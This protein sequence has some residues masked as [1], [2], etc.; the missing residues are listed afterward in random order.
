MGD[1]YVQHG[2]AE[3]AIISTLRNSTHIQNFY[4]GEPN[5]APDM[6][7]YQTGALWIECSLEG[8]TRMWPTIWR[9]RIDVNVFAKTRS[10]AHD[11][12]QV[13]EAVLFTLRGDRFPTYG[14]SITGVK[15]ET[16]M[17]RA[18]DALTG[19][20]RYVFALRFTVMPYYH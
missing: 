19:S 11:L 6:V 16:G 15:E 13:A 18:P 2:D 12:A 17:F 5:V 9:P 20:S 7:G 3:A 8:G 1:S 4:A 10:V 14:V